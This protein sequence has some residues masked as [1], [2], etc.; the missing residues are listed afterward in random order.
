MPDVQDLGAALDLVRRAVGA[1]FVDAALSAGGR[2][3]PG[4]DPD[5]V[6]AMPVWAFEPECDEADV[7]ISS[8]RLWGV[9]LLVEAL[10]VEDDEDAA[11]VAAV[12]DRYARWIAAAGAGRAVRPSRLPGRPGH[13]AVF[14]AAAPI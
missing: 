7:L 11:P 4:S 5:P 10:R 1:H 6:A 13:Y 8:A 12:R 9:D 3:G 14:A 2:P